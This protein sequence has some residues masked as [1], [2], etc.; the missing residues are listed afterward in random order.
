MES[1]RVEGLNANCK[2]SRFDE[3]CI[4]EFISNPQAYEVAPLS[5]IVSPSSIIIQ[6]LIEI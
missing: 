4:Q 2:L 5:L 3:D 6:T 1:E